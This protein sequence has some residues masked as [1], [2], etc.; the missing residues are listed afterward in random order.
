MMHNAGIESQLLKAG[1][2]VDM[3]LHQLVGQ[4]LT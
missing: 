1:S 2:Q 4:A 3:K